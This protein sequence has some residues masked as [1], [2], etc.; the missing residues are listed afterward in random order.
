MPLPV[1]TAEV[2]RWLPT[3]CGFRGFEQGRRAP[4][5]LRKRQY[6]ANGLGPPQPLGGNMT[7]DQLQLDVTA[8]LSWDPKVDGAAIA[9]SVDSG[10]MTLRGTVGSLREKHKAKKA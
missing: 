9:A 1:P 8:E 3:D 6:A 2:P 7:D 5:V 4:K 10:T